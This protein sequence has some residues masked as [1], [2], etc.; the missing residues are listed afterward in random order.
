MTHRLL[1]SI[2][3]SSSPTGLGHE[4]VD[5]QRDVLRH[6]RQKAAFVPGD[7]VSGHAESVSEFALSETEQE[8]LFSKLPTGQA[9]KR[10]PE[11]AP[12][13]NHLTGLSEHAQAAQ[14]VYRAEALLDPTLSHP[15]RGPPDADLGR[16]K[17]F[18]RATSGEVHFAP[19]EESTRFDSEAA[20]TLRADCTKQLTIP[21]VRGGD[22]HALRDRRIATFGRNLESDDQF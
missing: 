21:Q 2:S 18:A 17:P 6:A 13:V 1:C 9:G 10:L 22:V 20:P 14:S 19:F 8:P 16:G 5:G 12:P 15:E 11:G 4:T 3:S 7:R